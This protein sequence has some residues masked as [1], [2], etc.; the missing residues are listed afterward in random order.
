MS[1]STTADLTVPD[2][3]DTGQLL[4]DRLLA[5]LDLESIEKDIFRGR[6]LGDQNPNGHV[7]GGQVAAQ[8]LMAAGRTVDTERAVHSLHAYFIRAGDASVPIVFTVDRIRDGRSFTTRRVVAIQ[9]GHAIF[10]LEASFQL[11]QPGV[12][13][14]ATMPDSPAPETLL[15]VTGPIAPGEQSDF[16]AGLP[17]E[18]LRVPPA[19]PPPARRTNLQWLRATGR[20]PDDPLTQACAFTY[21][22]DLFPG[23]AIV[24]TLGIDYTDLRMASLD[25]AVW[26]HRPGRADDWLLVESES[27]SASGSRASVTGR[28][29]ARDG[30]QVATIVQEL[31]IRVSSTD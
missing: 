30:V 22:S 31:M 19:D 24:E 6:H 20:L 27:M 26:F 13:F 7:F 8:A 18:I 1:S 28:V 14:Q 17:F 29:F 25:H 5:L 11:D 21:A 2:E 4:A 16:E 15:A 3:S 23:S 12:D 9:H 10:A